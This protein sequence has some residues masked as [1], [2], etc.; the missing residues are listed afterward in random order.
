MQSA[1]ARTL[2]WAC[3]RHAQASHFVRPARKVRKI[4]PICKLPQS[5]RTIKFDREDTARTLAIPLPRSSRWHGASPNNPHGPWGD[6][7]IQPTWGN[8]DFDRTCVMEEQDA[9]Q[10]GRLL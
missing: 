6:S 9:M 8:Y 2:H 1:N 5:L 10:F 3:V 7:D 4:F